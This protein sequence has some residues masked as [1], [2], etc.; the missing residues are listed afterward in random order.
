[1]QLPEF[2]DFEAH[3]LGK[4]LRKRVSRIIRKMAI[5]RYSRYALFSGQLQILEDLLALEA[6][7]RSNRDQASSLRKKAG[8]LAKIAVQPGE[9][10]PEVVKRQI[11][12]IYD[13]SSSYDSAVKVLRYGRWLYRYVADGIAWR[14]YGFD[15]NA[16]RA[17]GAKE[18][19]VF[20]S[21]KD[22]IEDEIIFFKDLRSQGR[23]WL[24]VMHDL[25]NCLR[26]GD[27]S[28]FRNGVLDQLIELKIRQSGT[29]S[30][31]I[32]EKPRS[33]RETRQANRK[34]LISEYMQTGGLELLDKNLNGGKV[35]KA[36][37][38]EKY[39]YEAI[40]A[41]VRAARSHEHGFIE[42]EHGLMY[43]AFD[44]RTHGEED[45]LR[46]ASEQHPH[47][48]D[49]SFTFQQITPRFQE[50]HVSL[51]ITAMR[52][53]AGDMID[54]LFER[55][56]VISFINFRCVED[57]CRDNGISLHFDGS[58]KE[59]KIIVDS[60]PYLVEV[61]EGVW[62]RLLYEGFTLQSFVDL[63]K[64]TMIEAERIAI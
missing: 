3:P 1:M 23:E 14:A 10:M 27:F 64:A 8:E 63:I 54:I 18:P 20:L 61:R 51:P 38:V 35:F 42:P 22:G 34:R 43:L 16:I 44:T 24:P 31:D 12:E 58:G 13:T 60:K 7:L 5:L 56:A 46:N 57:Y 25:T 4:E 49:S 47:I 33:A 9:P 30:V 17:L 39:H 2:S 6:S 26:T 32:S 62:N 50:Y 53:S 40:S 28:L 59:R 11:S 55:V 41:V 19:V 37:V 36:N 15:R 52:L 48:F 21:S 45:A 29:K